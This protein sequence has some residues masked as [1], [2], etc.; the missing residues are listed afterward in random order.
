MAVLFAMANTSPEELDA[1]YASK[2]L[3]KNFQQQ[4]QQQQNGMASNQQQHD[5]RFVEKHPLLLLLMLRR[6]VETH[7]FF[8]N[9]GSCP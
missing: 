3:G 8:S 5:P 1:F 9:S 2:R 7:N 6:F 4:Q